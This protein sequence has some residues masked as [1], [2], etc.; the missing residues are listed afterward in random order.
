MDERTPDEDRVDPPN[1][2]TALEA[3]LLLAR[4][5]QNGEDAGGSVDWDD[6]NHA[7]HRAVEALEEAGVPLP[8]P[9]A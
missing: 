8:E 9:A 6:V 3:C 1:L 5:Y 4:A 2:S 7:W